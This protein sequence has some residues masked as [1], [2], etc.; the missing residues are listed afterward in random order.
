MKVIKRYLK[1]F[2][3]EASKKWGRK[4]PAVKVKPT[5]ASAAEEEQAVQE[6]D[7]GGKAKAADPVPL[8]ADADIYIGK[9]YEDS[10]PFPEVPVLAEQVIT[11]QME[12]LGL[13][14]PAI[15]SEAE[16][17][18]ADL[19]GTAREDFARAM[20]KTFFYRQNFFKNGADVSAPAADAA[21]V[22]L[23]DDLHIPGASEKPFA[24]TVEN[25]R[26]GIQFVTLREKQGEGKKDKISASA[27]GEAGTLSFANLG[28]S[29]FLWAATTTGP[30]FHNQRHGTA[31]AWETYLLLTAAD[32]VG[33]GGS[34]ASA[35]EAP[36]VAS[37]A[38]GALPTVRA[39]GGAALAQTEEAEPAAQGAVEKMSKQ[40][41][42]ALICGALMHDMGHSGIGQGYMYTVWEKYF[43]T[44]VQDFLAG[45]ENAIK[46]LVNPQA[47]LISHDWNDPQT[48]FGFYHGLRLKWMMDFVNN[49]P[50]AKP[51]GFSAK[52]IPVPEGTTFV[53]HDAEDIFD[54]GKK[55]LTWKANPGEDQKKMVIEQ[56]H[57]TLARELIA[58]TCTQINAFKEEALADLLDEKA[59]WN[60]ILGTDMSKHEGN[61][62]KMTDGKHSAIEI[63]LTEAVHNADIG[64]EA[65][66]ENE[67]K[68]TSTFSNFLATQG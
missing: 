17:K 24:D 54:G 2:W 9:L 55:T 16:P 46:N 12:I 60:A 38:E 51:E 53:N 44:P 59:L 5:S 13:T 18:L 61:M 4:L 56:A 50:K 32:A 52:L 31:V 48:S 66:C 58:T 41:R 45:G 42:F 10:P 65:R 3:P 1:A 22:S 68:E 43:T 47:S 7:G 19:G 15:L 23:S 25:E 28:P 63:L 39:A 57:A 37:S 20:M 49:S 14:I 8:N 35:G 11:M 64:T 33:D 26:S 29:A 34:K 6:G 27:P 21:E 36:A 67:A 40:Q 30:I 62:Q